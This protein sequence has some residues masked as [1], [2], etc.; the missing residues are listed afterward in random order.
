MHFWLRNMPIRTDKDEA[1]H[2]MQILLQL[3]EAQRLDLG[4]K[5]VFE[6]VVRSVVEWHSGKAATRDVKAR[7]KQVI[8]WMKSNG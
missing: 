6:S 5:D 1:R 2:C 4:D 3:I 8:L 7:L